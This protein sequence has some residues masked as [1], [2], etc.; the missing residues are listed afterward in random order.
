[1]NRLLEERL[2]AWKNQKDRKPLLLHGARQVGKTWILQS[3]GRQYYEN[4]IYLNLEATPSS[5]TLFE[6]DL[7]KE[8]M[9]RNIEAL[10]NQPFHPEKTLL[11]LDEI[12]SSDRAFTALKYFRENAA[13]YHVAAAGSLLGVAINHRKWS[14]P[15]G[16]VE[17]MTM[18]PMDFEE[19][20]LACG[21]ARLVDLIRTSYQ[22]RRPMPVALH[23]K[24]IEL[25]RCY[26]ITGG[27]PACVSL[28]AAERR[29]LTIPNLQNEIVGNYLGD[30]AKYASPA[31]AVR[32][33]AC[34]ASIP[35]QLAKD[36]HKF[37]YKIVQKGAGAAYF[38]ASLDWLEQAGV[39]LKCQKTEQGVNPIS[40]HADL[41]SFKI[42]MGD[43]GLLTMKSG[44]AQHSVLN[45]DHNAFLGALNENHVA[46]ALASKGHPLFYWTSGNTAEV[47]FLLESRDGTVIPIEVKKG[48]HVRS[49][50]LNLFMQRYQ[51][52]HAIRLS[53]KNFGWTETLWSI[54]LYAAFCI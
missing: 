48:E 24:A 14:F 36:N 21:E 17:T 9:L 25:Y 53:D 12:Q 38:G 32:I 10:T 18:Y 1:M 30:M 52:P 37:Q 19:F 2:V 50:S 45:N 15:V 13:G 23:E 22:E 5:A 20:L 41:S 11:I 27:M 16:Q 39:I 35:T 42:Y 33:R 34:Y 8:R 6:Q 29:L 4:T 26:L 28:Y 43:V 54:P 49:R 47:D 44:L 31:E 40:V 7:T 3:F 46:Q 51:P